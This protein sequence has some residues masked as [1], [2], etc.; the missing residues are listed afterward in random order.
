MNRECNKR[1]AF[2]ADDLPADETERFNDHLPNCDAC[3]EAVNQQ[4][5]IDVL[6]QSPVR[7]QLEPLPVDLVELMRTSVSRRRQV[8]RL[9]ACGLAAAA[10]ILVAAGWT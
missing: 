9:A 7:S 8:A 3:R 4:R 10:A 1:D 5:W 6:L 2:L